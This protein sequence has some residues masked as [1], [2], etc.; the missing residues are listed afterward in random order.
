MKIDIEEK[1]ISMKA[2]YGI[3]LV[4]LILGVSL[5]IVPVNFFTEMFNEIKTQSEDVYLYKGAYYLLG[6]GLVLIL[7][8]VGFAYPKI[9][10]KPM[11]SNMEK[12][13]I[14]AF[15]G[16]FILIFLL[17]NLIHYIVDDYLQDKKYF[18]CESKSKQWLH[19]KTIVYTKKMPCSEK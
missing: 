13:F 5:V 15:V 2:A 9:I 18:I 1:P 19:N 11:T 3:L 6:G 4:F 16:S 10:S 7:M 8:V 12:A 17:P 14:I